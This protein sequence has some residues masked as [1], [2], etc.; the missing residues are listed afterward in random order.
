[1]KTFFSGC[2]S[3]FIAYSAYPL[4]GKETLHLDRSHMA[5]S[6]HTIAGMDCNFA[7]QHW[8]LWAAISGDLSI[9]KLFWQ[10]SVQVQGRGTF[11]E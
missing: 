2:Q 8:N 7:I 10:D 5:L 9:Q 3:N 4:W 1:M 11:G 6:L